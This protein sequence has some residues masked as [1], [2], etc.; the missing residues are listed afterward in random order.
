MSFHRILAPVMLAVLGALPSAGATDPAALCLDAAERAAT[1]TGVPLRVLTAI[2]M[3]ETGRRSGGALAPWPW[4]LNRGGNGQWF[5]TREEALAA[6]ET[7]LAEGATNVDVGCFQLNWRWHGAA[8]A[9]AA[10]MIDPMHNAL[11][12]AHHLARL[13]SMTG[14]W[15]G[16]VAAYHSATPAKAAAYLARFDP[17]YAAL[18]DA[19]AEAAPAWAEARVNSYPLL[20]AGTASG[21]ASLVPQAA[22]ARPLFGG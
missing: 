1:E 12:A 11:Y 9:S 18:G 2:T 19:P 22:L 5:A 6:L 21:A 3:I 20:R 8:F 4:T 15:R 17:V 16:A 7:I 10:R 13:H 14:D